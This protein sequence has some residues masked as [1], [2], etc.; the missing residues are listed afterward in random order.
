MAGAGTAQVVHRNKCERVP[1]QRIYAWYG[2]VIVL[3]PRMRQVARYK[4]DIQES[5]RP[6]QCPKKGKC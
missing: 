3:S 6:S 2:V 5:R 4:A 1:L